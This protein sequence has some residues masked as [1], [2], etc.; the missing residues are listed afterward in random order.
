MSPTRDLHRAE[1]EVG[2]TVIFARD[3]ELH[4]GEIVYI[5][6]QRL[7]IEED[8]ELWVRKGSPLG[9]RKSSF[10]DVVKTQR[11]VERGPL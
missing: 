2:D 10:F 5:G 8:G 9:R 6:V 11:D 1:L 3:D 7:V 4:S